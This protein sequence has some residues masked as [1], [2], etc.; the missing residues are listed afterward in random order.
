MLLLKTGDAHGSDC[1]GLKSEWKLTK[2]RT[3]KIMMV[4]KSLGIKGWGNGARAKGLLRAEE[5]SA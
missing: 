5:K 2:V 1:R 3:E 4:S